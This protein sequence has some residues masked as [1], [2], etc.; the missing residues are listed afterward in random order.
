MAFKNVEHFLLKEQVIVRF[1]MENNEKFAQN[2]NEPL[3]VLVRGYC[4]GTAAMIKKEELDEKNRP[5]W[6]HLNHLMDVVRLD[7][8]MT[9]DFDFKH[10]YC[11]Y[12]KY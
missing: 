7:T 10:Y 4:E 11:E 2:S 6:N 9:K 12:G 8:L 1:E 3:G 5:E